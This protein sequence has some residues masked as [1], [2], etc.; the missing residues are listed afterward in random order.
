MNK[1]LPYLTK[2][3]HPNTPPIIRSVGSMFPVFLSN[4]SGIYPIH[5]HT[6]TYIHIYIHTHTYTYT[7]FSPS[8]AVVTS[9]MNGTRTPPS[10]TQDQQHPWTILP[11]SDWGTG[12]LVN[13]GVYPT[14]SDWTGALSYNNVAW[15]VT[16][17]VRLPDGTTITFWD[18]ILAPHWIMENI[19]KWVFFSDIFDISEPFQI[20]NGNG[21]RTLTVV[22]ITFKPQES[23]DNT[24]WAD[25]YNNHSNCVYGSFPEGWSIAPGS[26]NP[27]LVYPM[28]IPVAQPSPAPTSPRQ[29]VPISSSYNGKDEE[30]ESPDPQTQP[31]SASRIP[32]KRKRDEEPEGPGGHD[33]DIDSD[34]TT[35]HE[36]A[37][38]PP[39][40]NE[41]PHGP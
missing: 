8:N 29:C 31:N 6:C 10:Q 4:Y 24:N 19:N 9:I 25:H 41:R 5:K 1:F 28:Y 35:V 27:R 21:G 22:R 14:F 33:S 40:I 15:G 36:E 32:L 17:V 16:G 13:A 18:T 30:K 2:N 38:E 39:D 23:G 34:A 37:E 3:K 26:V 12:M 20:M 7:E 11:I